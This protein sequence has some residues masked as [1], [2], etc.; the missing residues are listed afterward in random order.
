MVNQLNINIIVISVKFNIYFLDFNIFDY[1]F[2]GKKQF[3][4]FF[5]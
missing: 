1:E 2:R 5:Y 4:V 3:V